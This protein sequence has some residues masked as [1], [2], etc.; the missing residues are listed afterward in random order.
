MAESVRVTL[1]QERAQKALEM[2]KEVKEMSNETTK[3]KYRSYAKS[4]ST[5]I[6]TNGL[7]QTLAFWNANTTKTGPD[8][9]AYKK[10]LNHM[11]LL[12]A[13]ENYSENIQQFIESEIE[14][15]VSQYRRD[16]KVALA[17]L[18]WLKR[19]ADAMLPEESGGE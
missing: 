7:A 18:V 12:V 19:F 11:A 3:K 10:L 5:L 4:A 2:V 17:S 9:E 6:L 14:K 15:P 16:T 13:G 1:E 8:A